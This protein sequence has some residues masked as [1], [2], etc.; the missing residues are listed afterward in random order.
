MS[1]GVL[2]RAVASSRIAV[3]AVA[4]M[5]AACRRATPASS[6]TLKRSHTCWTFMRP[7][8]PPSA[9]LTFGFASSLWIFW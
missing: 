9:R 6:G 5:P 2:P 8:P 1:M 7:Q 3:L 4:S